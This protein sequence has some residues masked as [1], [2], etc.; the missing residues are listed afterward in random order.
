MRQDDWAG[1]T[2]DNAGDSNY[3]WNDET[4]ARYVYLKKNT[5]ML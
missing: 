4:N 3:K 2:N 5:F 1:P